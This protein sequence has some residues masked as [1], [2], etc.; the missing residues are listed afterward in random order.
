MNSIFVSYDHL[1]EVHS[2]L[3]PFIFASGIAFPPPKKKQHLCN[4]RSKGRSFD[5]SY[6]LCVH[7]HTY[8]HMCTHIER[9]Q[10]DTFGGDEM[11]M[12]LIMIIPQYF[13]SPNSSSCL[14]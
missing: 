5:Y 8:T 1:G 7:T 3:F 14:H 11:L 13:F 12:A 10:G 6:H 2:L 4:F 9:G